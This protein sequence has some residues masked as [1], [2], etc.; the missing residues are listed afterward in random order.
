MDFNNFEDF[1]CRNLVTAEIKPDFNFSNGLKFSDDFA[2]I[3]F[4]SA[5]LMLDSKNLFTALDDGIAFDSSHFHTIG[6]HTFSSQMVDTSITKTGMIEG[7][8]DDDGNP[9]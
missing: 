4:G 1:K 9:T 5:S 7:T 8:L 2:Q 3:N 6:A